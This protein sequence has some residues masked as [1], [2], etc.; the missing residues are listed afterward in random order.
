MAKDVIVQNATRGL[1]LL[2]AARWCTSFLCKLRGLS[3]RRSLREDEG[4][5]LV[6]RRESRWGTAIHMFGMWFDL[7]IVWIQ[8]DGVVVDV[9]HARPWR[10]YVPRSP[11]Q[12]TLEARPE[13]LN[14]VRVG[15]RVE[16]MRHAFPQ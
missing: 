2:G 14:R 11:A 9:R 8:E 7:G 12:Y 6:E 4:L 5:V 10:I 13:V 1:V 3:L 15:D 16:F